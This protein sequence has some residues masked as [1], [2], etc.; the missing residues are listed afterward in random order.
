YAGPS[1]KAQTRTPIFSKAPAKTEFLAKQENPQSRT[2]GFQVSAFRADYQR[3]WA[4]ALLALAILWV[5]T[6]LRTA[7]PSLFLAAMSSA[8]KRVAM[9]G[10]ERLREASSNQRRASA[11]AR[12]GATSIGT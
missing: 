4:K 1:L 12:S 7:L 6:F 2:A 8:A 3:K 11:L 10:S 5:S 9:L